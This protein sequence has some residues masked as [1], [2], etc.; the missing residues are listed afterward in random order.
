MQHLCAS[1]SVLLPHSHTTYTLHADDN[2]T[3]EHVA[4][5]YLLYGDLT[6]GTVP[7]DNTCS[8]VYMYGM[9]RDGLRFVQQQHADFGWRTTTVFDHRRRVI[10]L[11][12][13]LEFSVRIGTMDARGCTRVLLSRVS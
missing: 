10:V 9:T 12:E 5:R 6:P 7:V 11:N 2:S 4:M 1:H 3:G 8:G 13:A